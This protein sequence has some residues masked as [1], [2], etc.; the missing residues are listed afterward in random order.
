MNGP[1]LPLKSID[2]SGLKSIFLRASTFRMKYFSAPKPTMRAI[3]FF[4][5][6]VNIVQLVHLIFAKC[7]SVLYH[8]SNKVVRHLPLFLRGSSFA[9]WKFYH[10]VRE[11]YQIFTPL[12][13]E[14]V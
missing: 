3:S 14:T 4:S 13:A 6:S 1:V 12:E 9:V 8:R 10:T 2:S 7:T 5:S 11:V